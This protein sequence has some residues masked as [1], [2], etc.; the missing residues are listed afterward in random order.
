MSDPTPTIP[1]DGAAGPMPIAKET[2]RALSPSQIA[3]LWT[4]AKVIQSTDSWFDA[5]EI[6]RAGE[7][8]LGPATYS[9][10]QEINRALYVN[11][12]R[13]EADMAQLVHD[14]TFG[15]PAL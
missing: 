8:D 1:T 9:T 2:I 10:R 5:D 15:P 7:G 14:W 3:R 4:A 13:Q 6:E 12:K 11:R